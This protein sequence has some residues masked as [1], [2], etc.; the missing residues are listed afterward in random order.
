MSTRKNKTLVNSLVFTGMTAFFAALTV[1]IFS[2]R[3]MFSLT[4]GPEAFETKS[5]GLSLYHEVWEKTQESLVFTD[6]LKDWSKWEH[7]FDAQLNTTAG[8]Q[9]ALNEL[10]EAGFEKPKEVKQANLEDVF[11][12]LTGRALRDD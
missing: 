6:R 8:A 3:P 9:A 2:I 11:I 5:E 4:E 10:V 7:K 12:H 1:I